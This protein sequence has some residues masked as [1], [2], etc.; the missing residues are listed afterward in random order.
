MP[1]PEDLFDRLRRVAAED[2]QK[3]K[4]IFLAIF[5][6]NS[7]ELAG[8][9]ARLSKPNEGR[10]RQMVANAI[11]V[12][13]AKGRI[14]SELVRWR[15]TETDE[16]T[17]RAIEG[18]LVDVDT[19]V[20][21]GS[22]NRSISM[23]GEL[24]EVYRYVSG[25]LRHRLRNAMFAAQSESSEVKKL[26]LNEVSPEVRT[27]IEKFSEAILTLGRE[28]EAIDVDPEYF[29]PSSKVL[30][31]WI[32]Q[33]NVQYASRFAPVA[34]RLVSEKSVQFR[35]FASDY[36][37]ETIFGNIWTNAQQAVGLNCQICIE[38]QI[39]GPDVRLRISDNG[40]GVPCDL[41]GIAFQ[42]EFSTKSEGR[43][44]GL[45]EIQDAAER[46]FGRVELYEVKP[47]ECRIQVYLPM[48]TR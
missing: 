8:F 5:E 4:E 33:W 3:A 14:V 27:T 45:L 24:A 35:V 25:R 23:P 39:A 2:P 43:G 19:A 1:E 40:Q 42:Q 18:A 32:T 44:R 46:L 48:D 34:L 10:L 9:L 21:V 7:A 11:R 36:L 12:H 20:P 26:A 30:A 17:R 37:L 31:E 28:L 29:R 15:E 13:P 16:F 47:G 6:S 22:A 38:F 41:R